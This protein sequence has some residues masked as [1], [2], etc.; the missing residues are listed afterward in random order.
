MRAIICWTLRNF[1]TVVS[2]WHELSYFFLTNIADII[3]IIIL[4]VHMMKL[5]I[6]KWH[7][8][9]QVK[10]IV[11]EKGFVPGFVELQ[12]IETQVDRKLKLGGS[13]WSG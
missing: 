5:L 13:R 1:H 11:S 4:S 8:V 10:Q 7:D 9:P 3:A 2:N 6:N 12:K